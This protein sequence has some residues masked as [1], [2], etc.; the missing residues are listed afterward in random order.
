M[1]R[2]MKK[3]VLSGLILS[4]FSL[5]STATVFAATFGNSVSGASSN[6]VLQIRYDGSAWNYIDSPYQ[7]TSFSYTRNG[8]T[9]MN[10]T[11][12]NGKVTGSVMDD[13]RWGDKYTTVFNWK[14]GPVGG[15]R[16]LNIINS[17]Q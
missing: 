4:V 12:Y 15:P 3:I 14:R 9:L 7:Y 1:K 11:A 17:N 10:K 13:L 16:P 8:K 2:K 6:E 5:F